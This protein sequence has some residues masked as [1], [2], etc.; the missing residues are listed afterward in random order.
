MTETNDEMLARFKKHIRDYKENVFFIFPNDEKEGND[1]CYYIE[2]N[3]FSEYS[4]LILNGMDDEE[5]ARIEYDHN[6]SDNDKYLELI[7]N[8]F[9]NFIGLD[10]IEEEYNTSKYIRHNITQLENLRGKL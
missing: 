9:V 3:V 6:L 10:L 8:T 4:D 5:V 1:K 7:I 2:T